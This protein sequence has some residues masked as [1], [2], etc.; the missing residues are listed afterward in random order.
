[1]F[2]G[3]AALAGLAGARL[4]PGM[5]LL[6]AALPCLAAPGYDTAI[7]HARV[8]DVRTGTVRAGTTILLRDGLI[9]DVG[10]DEAGTRAAAART[11]DAAGRLVT[12]GF[13]DVHFHSVEILGDSLTMQPDSIRSYRS[14]L[15][16]AY[17]PYGV[18]TVRSCGDD[19]RWMPMLRAWMEPSADAPDFYACGGALVSPDGH[20]YS[21]HVAVNGADAARAKVREYHDLGL[22]HVKVYW[23]LR[24]AE[25]GPVLDE[26]R[27]LGMNVVG[28]VDYRVI[29]IHRAMELGLRQFEH[30]YTLGVDAIDS[31]GYDYCNGQVFAD[32]YASCIHDGVMPGSFFVSRLEMFNTLGPENPAVTKVIADLAAHRAGVTPTLHVFAQRFGLAWFST[33]PRAPGFD[34]TDSLPDSSRARCRAGYG[35]LA[36]TVKKLYDAGVPITVGSDWADPGKA[37]LSE[38]LLLRDLGMPM[39]AVFAAATLNGAR[40]MGLESLTGAIEKGLK[41]NLVMFDADPL[42]DPRN[43]LSGMTVFKDGVP[44]ASTR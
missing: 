29:G 37:C 18:T 16:D 39:P 14:K 23:R 34:D 43:L 22:R 35:L 13:I 26:S 19:E 36:A 8:L 32:H 4:A 7:V 30:A 31:T 41:A 24:E 25:F 9:A 33:P 42:A 40:E 1:M 44:A 2:R 38:M 10:P 11:I 28:H 12:P 21:G 20:H 5:A 6:F 15:R 17:L 27:R 3:R